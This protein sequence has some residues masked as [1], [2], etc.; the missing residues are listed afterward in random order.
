VDGWALSNNTDKL[1]RVSVGPKKKKK[2]KNLKPEFRRI[3]KSR[4]ESRRP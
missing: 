3:E 1:G 2:K 4:K